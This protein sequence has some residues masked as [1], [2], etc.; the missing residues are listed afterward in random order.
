M[1]NLENANSPVPVSPPPLRT[2]DFMETAFVT[3]IAYGVFTL[4]SG[5]ALTIMVTMHNGT[6]ALSTAQLQ[7]LAMEG[8]WFGAALI[9]ATPPTI[10]VLWIAIRVAGREFSEYLALNW[11]SPG[12]LVRALP[13]AAIFFVIEIIA[14]GDAAG[15]SADPLLSVGG[16][17]GLLGLLIGGVIAGP[18]LE[19]FVVRGRMF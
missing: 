4:T 15:P 5:L 17:G 12:Q 11:P 9:I 6:R 1:S 2:W 8:R 19:G 16:V 7:A 18:V 10:A 13:V 14:S 3:L